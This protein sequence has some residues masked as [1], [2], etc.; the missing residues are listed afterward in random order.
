MVPRYELWRAVHPK[1]LSKILGSP[2]MGHGEPSHSRM[3]R[4][5]RIQHQIVKDSDGKDHLFMRFYVEGPNE[6]GT[7]QLV[8]L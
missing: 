5:R 6:S 1:Q 3:R 2:I 7:V 8:S 4:N